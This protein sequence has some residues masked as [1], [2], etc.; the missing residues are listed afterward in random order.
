MRFASAV[1]ALLVSMSF[2]LM[3]PILLGDL[4]DA[5]IPSFKA[6]HP[7]GWR[8]NI[9]QVAL[10]LMSTL[11]IQAGLT[12]FYSY[13]FS[14]VGEKAIIGVRRTL[15]SRL[16]SMPMSFF[17]EHR[18]GEL[19]SRLSNDVGQL[20]DMLTGVVPQALRQSI[21][22]LGGIAVIAVTSLKLSLVMI[23][24]F[25]LLILLA[26]VFGRRI[27]KFSRTA[28][29]R[30]AETATIVDETLQ[31]IAN[32]KAF[33]NE[34][35]E[36]RRYTSGL[37]GFLEAALSNAKYRA[38]LIAFIIVGIF[39]SIVLVLWQGARL[40]LAGELTHG[41][42]TRFIFCTVFVGGSVSS[43]AE[44]Y[45]LSQ[46]ALGASQRIRELLEE[47]P[48]ELTPSNLPKLTGAVEFSSVDFRY[49]SRPD[50]QVLRGLSLQAKPGEKIALVGPSGAGKST[51]VSLLLRFYEPDSG[52]LLLDG[53][54]AALHE[55]STVRANMAI[56]PQ[57]VLLFGGSIRDNIAYGRPDATEEAIMA[58]SR[59]AN[60]HEFIE[61]FP[62]GYNTLVGERGI[63]LSGGQRQRIAI[64]RALLK[65]PAILILDEATSSLDSESES[66]IQQA[67]KTLLAGRTA[68]IIAHRLATVRQVDRICVIED[69]T[70]T[71]SGTHAEL[72]EREG[73]TYQRLSQLQFTTQ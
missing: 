61:R 42:L 58:A 37:E 12:W 32:V 30:L 4:L 6:A 27:R 25:P 62:E 43:F 53:K 39:G 22:L 63:K 17:G 60:C 66:L 67:L 51:I 34:S 11:V 24:S 70:V 2:G 26:V 3:F 73:G 10:V 36:T 55:L 57:E 38:A 68:F 29:D 69:G 35:Y 7:A 13:S 20:Q 54:N 33:S 23:S 72:M 31:G 47:L 49:P 14:W 48:E 18:V 19:S 59:G 28:Q 65:D 44:V 46:K 16:I 56:V 71:E 15:Y 21:L 45:S 50:V 52:A 1:V 41:E 8:G 64:A 5:A 40:M 9:N